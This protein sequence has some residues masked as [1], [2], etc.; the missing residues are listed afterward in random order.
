MDI[1][2]DLPY[3]KALPYELWRQIFLQVPDQRSADALS[4]TC[5]ALNTVERENRARIRL[6]ARFSESVALAGATTKFASLSIVK[7]GTMAVR[8]SSVTNVEGLDDL[9]ARFAAESEW[10]QSLDDFLPD[11]DRLRPLLC[12]ARQLLDGMYGADTY[13]PTFA[14]YVQAVLAVEAWC[15]LPAL[16]VPVATLKSRFL[17]VFPHRVKRLLEYLVNIHLAGDPRFPAA[18]PSCEQ[19]TM[20]TNKYRNVDYRILVEELPF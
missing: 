2:T 7:Y 9:L 14:F 11:D 6:H 20:L 12:C 17:D 13:E 10:G 1:D 18:A 4:R 5:K 19:L 15:R 3:I 8:A 16:R